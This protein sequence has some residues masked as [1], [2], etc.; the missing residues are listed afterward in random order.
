MQR[1]SAEVNY[2]ECIVAVRLNGEL[3]ANTAVAAD[4]ALQEAITK[5]P[6]KPLL[7]DCTGLQYI[8]S[9]GL[10]VILSSL[11]ACNQNKTKLAFCGLQ[12][13]IKNVFT[14]LG[15]E[16]IIQTAKNEEEAIKILV[17]DGI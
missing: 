5:A 10:G 9:A 7:I 6:D 15:L 14:I 12:P 3:D 2:L 4:D 13:K 1:F 16:K 11:H 8:S 17:Q